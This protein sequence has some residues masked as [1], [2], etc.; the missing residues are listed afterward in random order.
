M[1]HC[2]DLLPEHFRFVRGVVDSQ[3]FSLNISR[4]ML[5]HGRQLK[6]I[7]TN[8]EKKVKAELKKLME[9]EPEKY[10]V[11]YKSFGIQLKYGIVGG[12]GANRD[13]LSDLIMLYSS[14]AEKL[15]PLAEY[16]KNMPEEQKYI[17]YAGGESIALL[18]KLP[19]AE[20]V[21]EKGYEIFYLTEE[22]DE[23]V[24]RTLG[25]FEEKEFRSVNDDDLGIEEDDDKKEAER[26]ETENKDLLEFVK[27]ALDGKVEAVRFSS[28]LKSHP[29]SLAAQGEISLEMEKYFK[30]MQG[31]Q[32]EGFMGDMRAQ[33][34]LELNA[35]HRSFSILKDAFENDKEKAAKYAKL[36]YGQSLLT[37]GVPLD[38]PSEF[39]DLISE[40]TFS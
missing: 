2:A 23:F 18:D 27:E 14:K 15:I 31:R 36:L 24:V 39:S 8:V 40:I 19:Q 26:Q 17:Y 37:A 9:D 32:Q 6:V 28:K 35:G 3:D 1:E 4:E 38:D 25:K 33:R 16:I 10:E 13:M 20:Q 11:F 7:A 30:S 12:F 29:V 34:V 22:I 5:Q 21:R